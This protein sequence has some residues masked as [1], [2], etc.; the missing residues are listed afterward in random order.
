MASKTPSTFGRATRTWFDSVFDAP[1]PVQADGWPAIARGANALMLA[2]TGSGK[3]LAA[4]LWALDSLARLP[5]D[6][7]EGIRVVYISPLKALVYDVERN[8][9]APLAGIRA[10]AARLGLPSR[11]TLVAVRTGDT[12]QRERQAMV[13]HPPD[14]LVTTPESLYLMLGSRVRENLRTVDL[15]IVD[16]IHAMA[17]TKR[18]AHLSL[19][20]ERLSALCDR[21]P[22]R[23]GLSATVRPVDEV[24][25]FLGGDR[26]VEIIDTSSPPRLSLRI[27]LPASQPVVQL[28]ARPAAPGALADDEEGGSILGKMRTGKPT[29]PDGSGPRS[30]WPGI[31]EQLLTEIRNHRTTIVFVNNRSATER[32]VQQLNEMAEEEIAL[33]HHGS[34]SRSRREQVEEALKSGHVRSIIATSS[35]ELG[36][37]MGMVDLVILVESP[38]AVARGLQRVGRA[39]HG[40]GET[41]HGIMIPKYKGDLL[42]TAVV[43]RGMLEGALEPL[44]IPRNALD[45]LSQQIVAMVAVEDRTVADIRALARRA[46]GFADLSDEALHGVLD[47]LSG[48]YPS[49]EFAELRPRLNWDRATGDLQARK[50]ARLIA[51]TNA[52]TIPD[53][54]LYGVHIGPTGPRIGEL[55]EEMVFEAR[56]GTTFVL[57]ASTWRIEDITRDRVVVSPAPGEPG[58]LPFWRGTGPGRPVGLGRRI[59]E[60]LREIDTRGPA[61]AKE[62]LTGH[63]PMVAATRD[64]LLEYLSE[65]RE[66]TGVLPSDRLI[67]VER[68]RD[69]I[70]DLRVCMLM[71]FGSPVHAPWGMALE[72]ILSR[73]AGFE[74]SVLWSDDGISLRFVD[75]PDDEDARMFDGEGLDRWAP[76]P[77]EI[78]ELLVEQLASTALFAGVFRESAARA[79]L[80]PRRMPGKRTPLWAQR[81]KSQTLLA[82]AKQYPAFPIVLEAYRACLQDVFDLTALREILT[83]VHRQEIRLVQVETERA[84]P[85]A[86][87]LVFDYVAAWLYEG[88]APLAERRAQ[89]LTLD[90]NLLRDLLGHAELR[91]LL[92]AEAI[93]AVEAELQGTATGYGARDADGLHDRLRRV[94]DL[95]EAEVLERCIE[96]ALPWLSELQRAYRAVSLKIGGEKRWVA[97]EDTALYRDALG[98]MP[99]SGLPAAFLGTVIEPMRQ[100]VVRYARTHVP[101]TAR[102]LAARYGVRPGQVTPLLEALTTAGHLL[103][104]EFRPG[105]V[106]REWVDPAVLRRI[107]RRSLA[108][109]RGQAA[110]VGGQ[111][112]ARFLLS[113][114]GLDKDGDLILEEVLTRLEGA[115]LAFSELEKRILKPRVSDY[116]SSDLDELT[117]TGQWVWVG[118]GALGQKDGRIRLFRRDRAPLLLTEPAE[119]E[120]PSPVHSALLAHLTERGA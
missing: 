6:A 10:T 70:G 60:L 65:Q 55:D 51:A 40:V 41:S 35:L 120:A 1:T 2:P 83:A 86:R 49:T 57:G 33:A 94:G 30:F 119:W 26:P 44:R 15:V 63:Y 97:V 98:C 68:F 90:R 88:D 74:V 78:E 67:V 27:T 20:L 101:F 46:R 8:L 47:M 113:W 79:L 84:S 21:D 77:E 105:G 52:G 11:D 71:P 62:Y 31:H 45:V 118:Q 25:A 93:A 111:T 32:L 59:G 39:G 103:H 109:I 91:Q 3:T 75:D 95:N 82:A 50:G 54:G 56:P 43:A 36:I 66:A 73:R 87:S 104:G 16:E 58:Q 96:P 28:G 4:F 69:E 12:P 112:F 92:D 37:D 42:E 18:G 115:P 19:T 53:R 72:A 64:T 23:V 48:K 107:R 13:R 106:E 108:A 7:P 81:L 89:A 17:G 116:Q 100:L 24:A 22:Q 99:P 61:A 117:A 114:H 76:D 5:A 85:F 110:P 29:R 38:G 14:V 34:L 102:E 80:L 9:R